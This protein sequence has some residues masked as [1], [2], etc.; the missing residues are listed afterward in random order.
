MLAANI[1][2]NY[3][4]HLPQHKYWGVGGNTLSVTPFEIN[5]YANNVKQCHNCLRIPTFQISFQEL[6]K[7]FKF[8]L[9]AVL[10]Q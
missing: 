9:C 4:R 1:G 5:A 7:Q 8:K 10:H 2:N 6:L 3:M